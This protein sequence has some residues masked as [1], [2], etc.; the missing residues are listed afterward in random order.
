[1]MN[2]ILS[3]VR[4]VIQKPLTFTTSK[5]GVWVAGKTLIQSLTL[6]LYVGDAMKTMGIK[7]SL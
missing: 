6:W 2:R 3:R 4:F 1:M 5:P 7:S